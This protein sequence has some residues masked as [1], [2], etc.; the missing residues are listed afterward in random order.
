MVCVENTLEQKGEAFYDGF[1]SFCSR[2]LDN[3]K[4]K[5]NQGD[6]LFRS[7]NTP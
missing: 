7:L 6:R 1:H 4:L 2:L 5:L 3:I